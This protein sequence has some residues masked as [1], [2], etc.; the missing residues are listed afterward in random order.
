MADLRS[1]ISLQMQTFLRIQNAVEDA[2]E[3]AN[4]TLTRHI[5]ST[6]LEVLEANWD[7]FQRDHDQICQTSVDILNQE[8]YMTKKTFERCQ[9]FYIQAKASY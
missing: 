7:K 5:V 4:A 2:A 6:R 9:E 8:S 1:Q 3:E